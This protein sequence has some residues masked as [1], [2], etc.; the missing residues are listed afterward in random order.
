MATSRQSPVLLYLIMVLGL[1]LGFLY[2]TQTDPASSVQPVESRY[3]LTSM[4]GLENIRIDYSLLST[5]QFQQLRT[6]GAF[7]LTPESGGSG[8]P[9]Q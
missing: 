9:F 1:V 6:F 5:E 4:R 8:N 2:T 3:Q 7:P